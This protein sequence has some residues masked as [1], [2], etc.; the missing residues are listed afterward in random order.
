MQVG[1]EF[2]GFGINMDFV[3]IGQDQQYLV[4]L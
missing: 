2:K 3:V 1:D 4:V